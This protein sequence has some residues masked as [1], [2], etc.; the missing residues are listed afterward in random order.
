M[1][2]RSGCGVITRKRLPGPRATLDDLR[3]AVTTLEETER[4]ARRVLGGARRPQRRLR[5]DLQDARATLRAISPG[6]GEPLREA[7]A[8]C[9]PPRGA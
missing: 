1:K 3:A 7:T 6:D 4:V 5:T 8:A 9:T 2:S